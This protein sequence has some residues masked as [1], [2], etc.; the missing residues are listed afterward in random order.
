MEFSV[1]P[2]HVTRFID[3]VFLGAPRRLFVVGRRLLALVNY[4]TSFTLNLRLILTPLYG[5]YTRIGRLIG[6]VF[7]LLSIIVGLVVLTVL[8]I[9]VLV[10]PFIWYLALFGLFF[11][12]KFYTM[13]VLTLAFLLWY[14]YSSNKPAKSG[15][16]RPQV[17]RVVANINIRG[18][19]EIKDFVIGKNF[20]DY[21]VRLEVANTGFVNEIS[22][23]Y[24]YED[25][26]KLIK[27]WVTISQEYLTKFGNL[28]VEPEQLLLAIVSTL[29]NLEKFLY[30]YNLVFADLERCAAWLVDVRNQKEMVHVWQDHYKLLVMGGIGKGLTGRVTPDL[31]AVSTDFTQQVKKGLVEK[32]YWRM[33]EIKRVAELLGGSN[34]NVLIIGSPGCGKT[35]IVKGI[36][37]NVIRGTE[38]EQLRFKRIVSLEVGKI[39]AGTKSSGDV[40]D[41]LK[42]AVE[43]ALG[44]GDVILFV[45][46]IHTLIAGSQTEDTRTSSA[47]TVLTNY[48]TDGRLQFI[49]ATNIENYRHY[50]EPNGSFSQ[51]FQVVEIPPSSKE[52]TLEILKVKAENLERM[53]RLKITFR[54]LKTI[55]E[56][57]DKLI[58]ERVFPDKAVDILN[59]CVAQVAKKT[60]EVNSSEV[61]EVL[62]EVTHI[63]VSAVSQDESQKLLNIEAEMKKRVIGQDEAINMIGSALKRARAG[64]RNESK[65][66]ASFLFV[67]TT[68]VGK[69]ETAK[70]LARVYF[71]DE[72]LMIRLDMSEYQQQ[73][74]ISR[75]LGSPDGSTKGVLTEAV[76]SRPFALILLDEIEKAH[77]D[78]LLAFLQVLDDG[79]LTDS[80]GTTVDFTNTIIIAT[81]N[82]GT[83][84]IQGVFARNGNFDEMKELALKDVRDKFAPEFLNRFNGVIVYKPLSTESVRKIAEIM[85]N[86]VRKLGEAK[87]IKVYFKPILM[88]ELLKR[89]YNPEWG[90]RPMAR[91]IEESVE[92]Y[93][94]I[95][96]LA[97]EI[98]G[99]DSIELGTEVF[100]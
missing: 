61:L 30:K 83:R 43:D 45:D 1:R 56:M 76:R 79:R 88:D 78:I 68:G 27:N 95:K 98:V 29:P 69:T 13:Y 71:G 15:E 41:K 57:G 85:L 80:S 26:R 16:F 90:A 55:V 52:E 39:L 92:N 3:F 8:S 40:A 100:I 66:M 67:G 24:T 82:V 49:G 28:F 6:L 72:K 21:F 22:G 75:L 63:P 19:L 94:A 96:I 48:L 54:A 44:S 38:F 59:R 34:R 33:E 77:Q 70:T 5:D 51:L 53:Y 4:E 91:V 17:S 35:G 11:V 46:D 7:R 37:Y 74:S 12:L 14:L 64:M 25:S 89:G 81:S 10:S 73:D 86:G 31:D 2:Q 23:T 42:K 50:I 65:P 36:A 93:L 58:H 18:N 20:N 84:S 9:F 62:S 87:G 99:G 97:K 32:T 60:K 47:Y